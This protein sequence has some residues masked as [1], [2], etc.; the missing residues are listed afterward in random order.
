MPDELLIARNPDLESALPYL[1]RVPLGARGLVLKAREPWPRTS[2]VYCHRVDGWPADAEVIE[3][4]AVR[5]CTSRGSAVDLVLARARE[6][7]SQLVVTRARGREVIFWQSP[8]TVKQA[9]PAVAVPTARAHGQVLD[10]LK[11]PGRSTRT[12][13]PASRPAPGGSAYRPATTPSR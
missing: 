1:I 4:L 2:K 10:I 9:R 5:S 7:R 12:A 11:T 6:N 3:R 13:S 8:R